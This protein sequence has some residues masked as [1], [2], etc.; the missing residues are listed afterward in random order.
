MMD[1]KQ[2]KVLFFYPKLF[3]F[4]QIDKEILEKQFDVKSFEFGPSSKIF[5][6]IS[7]IKQFFFL[8]WQIRN[9][10]VIV[11]DFAGYVSFLPTLFGKIFSVPTLMILCGTEC[12]SF[13]SIHYGNFNKKLLGLFTSWSY[14]MAT[15]LAPV[16]KSMVLSNYTYDDKDFPKQGYRYFCPFANQPFTELN[17]GFN[18]ER[19]YYTGIN[20][21]PNSFLTVV[22]N[23]EGST[24]YRK[25]LDLIIEAA[26]ELPEFS[27]TIIGR[28]ERLNAIEKSS[29]ITIHPWI[30]NEELKNYY[31]AHEFYLQISMIEGFPNT[32]GEAMLCGCI[33]IGSDAASIPEII[34][35]CGFILKKKNSAMFTQLLRE[36]SI[37]NKQNLSQCSMERIKQNW[38]SDRRAKELIQIVSGSIK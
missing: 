18:A 12:Y 6:P 25:G 28:G 30:P 21:N 36:A 1:N 24:F 20:R 9:T 35:D 23:S 31:S 11:C 34:G 27:F 5:T 32:L 4:I 26:K 17:Y 3:T 14:K 10:K 7:F 38:P 13:P 37:C 16:H 29:N 15:H 2:K 22:S 33:P 8:V 19:F